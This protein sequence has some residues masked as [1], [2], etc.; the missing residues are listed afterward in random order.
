VKV[1]SVHTRPRYSTGHYHIQADPHSPTGRQSRARGV[2]LGQGERV[3]SM[4][5]GRR[6]KW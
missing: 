2:G 5:R 3:C 4:G 6:F 1:V